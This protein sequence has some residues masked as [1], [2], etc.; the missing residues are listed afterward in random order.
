MEIILSLPFLVDFL[1]ATVRLAT[2]LALAASGEIIAERSGVLNIGLEGMMLTGAF[3]AVVGSY[4]TGSPWWGL[5]CALVA[6][7]LMGLLLA[8]LSVTLRADQIVSGVGINL[9][10]LG[11]TGVL[12]KV[13]FK[14]S[15][16]PTQV[17]AL[18]PWR[19]PLLERIPILGP[20]LFQ[21][22]PLVY[23]AFL[24]VLLL[25][26]FLLHTEWGLALRAVGEHPRAADTV[27]INIYLVRYL[28]VMVCGMLAGLGGAV[29]SV[30]HLNAFV[31]NMTAGR[32]FI[33]LA[34]V[35]FGKW[36]PWG[37]LGASLLFGAAD[38]MQL[39]LQ[40][41]GFQ[42]PYQFLLMAPYIVTLLALVG[43]VGRAIGPA[44]LTI[45]YSKDEA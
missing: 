39:R 45:N 10:A 8:F 24:L 35:I 9:L 19:I 2:P 36:N 23:L 16:L 6:G 7:G 5:V 37:V 4:F 25:H 26:V 1:S 43:L 28:S 30:G 17:N 13:L 3:F 31:E 14:H 44:A 42:V 38:A 22:I 20:I 21:Q 33:A 15:G 12:F 34:A 29:L 41:L 40:A 27:G 18:A 11:L 32:G